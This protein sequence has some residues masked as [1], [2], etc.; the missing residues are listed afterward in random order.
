M[1]PMIPVGDAQ[2]FM[3][4]RDS[5]GD[6]Y[7]LNIVIEEPVL[8]TSCD[9]RFYGTVTISGVLKERTSVLLNENEVKERVLNENN[10][11]S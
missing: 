7:G 4:F 3:V 8:T 6:L 11:L 1:N 2:A 10:G 9:D 5:N